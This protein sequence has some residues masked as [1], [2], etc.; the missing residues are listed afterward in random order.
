MK[1]E[2]N[3]SLVLVEDFAF[4]AEVQLDS[5]GLSEFYNVENWKSLASL[6]DCKKLSR[7]SC[8][9]EKKPPEPKGL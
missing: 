2:S 7:T 5:I 3:A 6:L 9:S 4:L 8:F 1:F